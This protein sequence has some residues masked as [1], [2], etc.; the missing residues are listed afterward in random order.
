[1]KDSNIHVHV[2]VHVQV[3]V[4]V[5]IIFGTCTCICTT[6]TQGAALSCNSLISR[7]SPT[8]AF[9]DLRRSMNNYACVEKGEPGDKASLALEQKLGLNCTSDHIHVHVHTNM[10]VYNVHVHVHTAVHQIYIYICKCIQT[11]VVQ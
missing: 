10:H 8:R 6:Y 7:F 11:H 3:H 9:T 5:H 1:M 4:V 2:H